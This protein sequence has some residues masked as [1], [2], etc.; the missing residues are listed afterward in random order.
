MEL[1]NNSD[2]MDMLLAQ[3]QDEDMKSVFEYLETGNISRN[4]VSMVYRKYLDK[5]TIQQDLL[6]YN[7]HSNWITVVPAKIQRDILKLTH[8][9]IYAGHFGVFKTHRRIL[10]SFWWP[11]LYENV[12]QL[13]KDC[14]QC[15]TTKSRGKLHGTMGK[16]EWPTKPLDCISIDFLVDLPTT[17]QGHNHIMVVNDMFSKHVK[18]YLIK[19]RKAPTAA[20]CI[21]DYSLNFGIPLKILSDRDPAYESELFQSLMKLFGVKKSRTSGY[22]PQANAVTE[23][24]NRNIKEFL[25]IYIAESKIEWDQF[26]RELAYA[27][28]TSVHSSTIYTPCQLFFG[29]KFRVPHELLY[30]SF[31]VEKRGY[32]F[33][34]FVNE[35]NLMF[36]IARENMKWRQDKFATYYDKK[37]HDTVLSEGDLVLIYQPRLKR[38]KLA[39]KWT[40][41]GKVTKTL[42]PVYEIEVQTAKGTEKIWLPRDRLRKVPDNFDDVHIDTDLHGR[43][44]DVCNDTANADINESESEDESSDSEEEEIVENANVQRYPL[45]QRQRNRYYDGF[46]FNYLC[47]L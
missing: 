25:T 43:E 2:A 16:R 6:K 38:S 19:D 1:S 31:D 35:L 4:D 20:K 42:H 18:L 45:R 46:V 15:L 12:V 24:M 36:K 28:N 13:V 29:R 33:D 34:Q 22:R 30:G 44:E 32:S 39:A 37:R 14:R 23:Q 10:A 27:Y 9:D 21:F 8:S 7:H 41:P 5:L 11:K 3:R 26:L 47:S 40:G 17:K